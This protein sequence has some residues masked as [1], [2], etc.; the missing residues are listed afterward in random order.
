MSGSNVVWI[1]LGTVLAIAVILTALAAAVFIYQRRF[2]ALH[3]E[4]A[5]KLIA[6]HEE[7]RAYVA[8]EVHDDALQRVALLQHDVSEW[9]ALDNGNGSERE[10][11]R[12][13]ALRDELADL[14]V[15]LRRVAHRLHP[16]IIEQGGLV[17]ALA[18]LAEDN[19]R[20]SGLNI[21]TRLPPFSAERIIDRERALIL[22]RIAQEAL[23]NVAKHANA[24]KAELTVELAKGQLTLVVSDNGQGF[25][26]AGPQSTAGLGL[27]SMGERARLA[28]G[29]FSL[30]SKPGA[31]TTIRVTVP[32]RSA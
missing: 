17:P 5:K 25:D 23:R 26:S 4:Y 32:L 29:S 14:G 1:Y 11:A 24:T 31:G 6:A 12:S 16:A 8:R 30:F 9:A 7:E 28:D 27:I 22:F 20:M 13:R 15:M 21:E 3:R 2:L 19:E 10:K 18:Q